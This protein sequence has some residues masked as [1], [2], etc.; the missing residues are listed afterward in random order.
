MHRR[1][2]IT[3]IGIVSPLGHRLDVF[4]KNLTS[5]RSG[6]REITTFDASNYPTRIAAEVHDWSLSDVG[7]NPRQFAG[8]PRQTSFALGAGIMAMADSQL[9]LERFDPRFAGVY[10]GCGEPFAPFPSV[11]E[12][13]GRRLDP[14][15]VL[16]NQDTD[17]ALRLFDPDSQRQFDPNL[18]AI[19]LA[20]R[21]N[22]QGPALNCIAACVS[23]SQAI[24]QAVR[25]IRRGQVN[26]M[27]CGGAHS[28]IHELGVTGFSRLSALSQ[29]NDA[30]Q[31][32]S[33][34]FDRGRD[35][36]VV[37][38]GAAMFV[39]EEYEQARKRGAVIYGEVT[40]YGSAQ[41]AFRVTDTHP[42]GR[43]SVSAITRAMKDAGLGVRDLGYINA[44]G[45]GTVLNDKVETLALKTALGDAAYSI[46]VSSTKSMLGHATTACGAL[47]LAVA[48]L[49]L[50]TNT[51]PPTINYETPDPECDLDYI[52]NFARDVKCRHILSNNIGFGGQNAALIVSRVSKERSASLARVA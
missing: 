29:N 28:C 37:G 39:A 2:V 50:K 43:G 8:A 12:K 25:M 32:A 30:P 13:A 38:E 6:V 4:W 42:D 23:A 21:L 10:L 24:G 16:T 18:P 52:P 20:G 31:Q 47:E 44:H 7:E 41:D 46:P 1:V 35:G 48:L 3:G 17:T 40:G 15:V 36:F 45:T 9:R 33:R 34:P 5:G 27:L 51:L 19:L 22:L 26:T 49:A 14:P 11:V